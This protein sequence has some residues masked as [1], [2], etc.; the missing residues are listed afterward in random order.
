MNVAT[1]LT[2]GLDGGPVHFSAYRG[3]VRRRIVLKNG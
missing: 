2:K 1:G 3:M